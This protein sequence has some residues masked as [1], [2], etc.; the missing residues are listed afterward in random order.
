MAAS[1]HPL[2]YLGRFGSQRDPPFYLVCAA[3]T[4]VGQL[5]CCFDSGAIEVAYGSDAR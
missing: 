4:A 5:L 1:L 3:H 2:Q